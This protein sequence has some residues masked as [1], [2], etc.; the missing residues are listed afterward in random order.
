M[1]RTRV[2]AQL[3]PQPAQRYTASVERRNDNP[4][5][6]IN[7]TNNKNTELGATSS[8]PTE[9][10]ASPL[11]SRRPAGIQPVRYS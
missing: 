3:S 4:Q 1:L 7:Y 6:A 11:A 8:K 5:H 10:E 2:R 9:S